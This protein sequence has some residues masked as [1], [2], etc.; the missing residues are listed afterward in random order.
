MTMPELL[1]V[2]VEPLPHLNGDIE[3]IL[4]S[5]I[6]GRFVDHDVGSPRHSNRA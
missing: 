3:S 4:E 6:G 1:W 2:E 5:V